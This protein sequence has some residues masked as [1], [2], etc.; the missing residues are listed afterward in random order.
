MLQ[1]AK[2]LI[3]I[4]VLLLAGLVFFRWAL[5]RGDRHGVIT[6]KVVA[7]TV[8]TPVV[9]LFGYDVLVFYAYLTCAIA[10]TSRTRAQLAATYVTMLPMMPFL[11][12]QS[13]TESVYL[14]PL[15]AVFAMN[16]GALIGFLITPGKRHFA[17]PGFDLAVVLLIVLFV[18]VIGRDVSFTS[19]LRSIIIYSLQYGVPYLVISRSVSRRED[20]DLIL[21]RLALGAT[22]CAVVGVFQMMRHWLLYQT[23]Y[24]SLHVDMA[25]GSA[26]LAIRGGLMRSG[27]TLMDYTPGGVF[28]ASALMIMP[29]LRH[30]FD[31][32]RFWPLIGVILLGLFATQLRGGWIAAA[33]GFAYL[34]AYRGK[35][36]KAVLLAVGGLVAQSVLFLLVAG[37][38]RVAEIVGAGGASRVTA[39]YRKDLLL[40]G[41]KQVVQHPLFGQTPKQLAVSLSDLEQGQHIVDYVNTHLYVAMVAG[42]SGLAIWLGTWIAV[43]LP[44]WR[45]RTVGKKVAN[46]AEVPGA[47]VVAS[48]VA[49]ATTSPIDRNTA[50]SVIAMALSGACYAFARSSRLSA[51]SAPT[52]QAVGPGRQIVA[53]IGRGVAVRP[54]RSQTTVP[55]R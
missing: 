44:T 47:I 29:Y 43:V 10:F 7:L 23:F 33:V 20:L 50:W 49:L 46:P 26:T 31:A 11:G 28:L 2:T 4:E 32:L 8:L 13:A 41:M 35:W 25:L 48:M 54:T 15:S 9:G 16:V 38:G 3:F 14:F 22:L 30:R 24:E 34:L 37:S 1:H 6:P 17:R 21:L 42:L 5:A 39:D 53:A 18:F 40:R 36:D 27:G 19:I 45:H 52:A 55:S 12:Q 51:G